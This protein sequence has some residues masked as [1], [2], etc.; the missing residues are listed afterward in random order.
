MTLQAVAR[1]RAARRRAAEKERACDETAAMALQAAWRAALGRRVAAARAEDNLDK[2]ASQKAVEE[3]AARAER[4]ATVVQAAAR[5]RMARRRAKGAPVRFEAEV[6][7]RIQLLFVAE[8]GNGDADLGDRSDE[9]HEDDAADSGAEE[10]AQQPEYEHSQAPRMI[11]HEDNFQ[12]DAASIIT[13][14][15]KVQALFRG[16]ATR[17]AV[18]RQRGQELQQLELRWIKLLSLIGH[19]NRGCLFQ[20]PAAVALRRWH[21]HTARQAAYRRVETR[22]AARQTAAWFICWRSA[23]HAKLAWRRSFVRASTRGRARRQACA[24]FAAW[25]KLSHEPSAQVTAKTEAEN[26]GGQ[27]IVQEQRAAVAAAAAARVVAAA[28][29]VAVATTPKVHQFV[30]QNQMRARRVMRIWTSW[31]RQQARVAAAEAM[32]A[33]TDAEEHAHWQRD[34]ALAA[35]KTASHCMERADAGSS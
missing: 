11:L 33:R 28:L 27:T 26:R 22:V 10:E 9:R 20:P 2:F 17:R 14:T 15:S 8:P 5:G 23:V 3:E 19:M 18:A 13:C 25:V 4:G 35:T 1:G 31:V 12:K 24:V 21:R 29:S 30:W 6:Q 16:R 34:R 7:A 32:A